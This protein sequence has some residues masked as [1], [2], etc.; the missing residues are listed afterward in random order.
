MML[1]RRG[2]SDADLESFRRVRLAVVPHERAL[3]VAEMRAASG[4]DTVHLL[5]ERDGEVLGSGLADRSDLSGAAV[6]IARV[7]PEFRRQ[8]I[9]TALFRAL[10]DHA[11]RL[12]CE[13]VV[14]HA[15]DLGSRSF[16]ERFDFVEID[17]QIEQVRKVG[18]EP[19]VAAPDGVDFVTVAQ[20]P[21]LWDAAYDRVGVQAFADMALTAPLRVS[22][23]QWRQEW[24]G[25]P[26]AMIL[27]LAGGEIIGLAGLMA[28]VDD[29][30]RAENALTA[31]RRE[32]RG[33]GVASA[34]KRW[35]LAWAAAH[36]I[37]EVYTWTQ[38]GNADM[39]RLNEHLGYV[40]RFQSFT[41]RAPAN[42]SH[43]FPG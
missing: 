32:W 5:A 15:D 17:R 23:E 43:G 20:Q 41:M 29:P 7:L 21:Q 36:G 28:D 9:G 3:T 38:A 26:E 33:R 40:T 2:E 4:P 22:R 34:L 31:V 8:G 6:V 19:A 30:T 27:A 25:M 16:V 10:L 12:G 18:T 24:L 1:V 35:T 13:Y 39:R 11:D 42:R 14:S 37:R